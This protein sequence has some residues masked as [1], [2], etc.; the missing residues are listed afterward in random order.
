MKHIKTLNI[1][2]GARIT[3]LG[4]LILLLNAATGLTAYAA[5]A[6][7]SNVAPIQWGACAAAPA[8]IPD[9]GQQ[10]ATISVPLNYSDPNG[11]HISVSVSR[12][13]AAQPSQRRGVLLMNP[14]GPGGPGLDMPRIATVIMPQSV[15]NKYDLIGFDPRGV[16][17]S[18][19]LTCGMNGA[20]SN[21]AL[22]MLTQQHSFTA[23][24]AYAQQVAQA[25]GAATGSDLAYYNTPNTARDMDQIRQALGESKINYFAWS[26]GTYLGAV[27]A[28]LFPANSDRFVLDSNVNPSWTWRQQFRSF[29]LGGSI[30]FPDFLNWAAANDSTYHLGATADAVH[31]TYSKLLSKLQQKPITFSD[32][33]LFDDAFFREES[34]F[35]IGEPDSAF[36]ALAS[37]WQAVNEDQPLDLAAAPDNDNPVA[38]GLAITC[39]D[40]AWSRSP[41]QYQSELN[42]DI[43]QYPDFGELGSNIWPCAY[44]PNQ[45]PSQQP[46]TISSQG[47]TNILLVQNK[48]DPVTPYAGGLGMHQ[49]LGNRSRLL[50][51]DA[52]AGHAIAYLSK[53]A[54]ADDTV[55]NYLVDGTLPAS[56][57]SC[58][59]S[60]SAT[61]A[62]TPQHSLA[63]PSSYGAATHKLRH[64]M[65]DGLTAAGIQ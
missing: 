8:G 11:K 31:Q 2:R 53:V 65:Q 60:A 56:D 15:L 52:P 17:T 33:T 36:P 40:A 5:P 18:T 24:A 41:S 64:W 51:V 26:Y 61:P 22:P 63:S 10:C 45:M 30:R 14:G 39:N 3:L 32:G 29:G 35:S 57:T 43:A 44:W 12:I 37:V 7:P 59:Q 54:C 13:P 47:A 48:R 58:V 4:G 38:S 55:T 9:G 21:R 27:Y 49:A 20:Q 34:F 16:G 23:T 1:L 50:S 46:V 62:A 28:S 6:S 42:A 19:P 25:C